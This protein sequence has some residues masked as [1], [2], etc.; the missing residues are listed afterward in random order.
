MGS[1]VFFA[2]LTT[3]EVIY[4]YYFYDSNHVMHF[5]MIFPIRWMGLRGGGG[6]GFVGGNGAS[7]AAVGAGWR[8][9]S[10]S[11]GAGCGGKN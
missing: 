3:L 9:L 1:V 7:A 11:G 2:Q 10:I 6:R 8:E 5:I 4:I